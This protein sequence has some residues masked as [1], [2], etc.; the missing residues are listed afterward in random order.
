MNVISRKSFKAHVQCNLE[1]EGV[2]VLAVLCFLFC[3]GRPGQIH[4][5]VIDFLLREGTVY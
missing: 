4:F 5:Q 2:F 3:Q 1:T